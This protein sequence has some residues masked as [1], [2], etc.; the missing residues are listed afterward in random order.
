MYVVLDE[1]GIFGV[2]LDE[3]AAHL[4]KE[5]VAGHVWSR[6][7]TFRP[8]ADLSGEERQAARQHFGALGTQQ[9]REPGEVHRREMRIIKR[10]GKRPLLINLI[11][12]DNGVG[13]TQDV[14]LLR[15]LFAGEGHEVRFVEW[16]DGSGD[17]DINVYLELFDQRHLRTA[18]V[19]I[20]LF[21]LEWYDKHHVSSLGQMTQL[22]AKSQEAYRIYEHHGRGAWP[23]YFT[24][25][26]SR[27]MRTDLGEGPGKV[28]ERICLHVRG[29]A[30][31]KA[32][33][34]VLETWRRHG[35][36][37]PKLIVTSAQEF[38][39]CGPHQNHP[40][41]TVDIGYKS[42]AELATL[43]TRCRFHVCPSE[44]EGWGHYIAE[45]ISCE[46]VVVTVD[47]SPMN[48]HIRPDFGILLPS[49]PVERGLV[50]RHRTDP[51]VM[52]QAILM[53]MR[54]DDAELDEM[55]KRARRHWEARQAAFREKALALV[56][57]V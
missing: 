42:E 19:H 47:A 12:H 22:W 48:E 30:S 4:L 52:A 55:G 17:A 29:K 40:N 7:V 36:K 14:R 57:M 43:M 34:I 41:V 11:S 2:D 18:P 53:L 16:R 1:R 56:S 26:L 8:M 23:V 21:N 5:K 6:T 9:A 44:T 3:L 35:D 38:D 24:G 51:D 46:A 20:G 32:T 54:K 49:A 28:K 37:L 39:G 25:F 10:T 50:V 27:D 33:D 45:A 15:E 31:Q 13:L